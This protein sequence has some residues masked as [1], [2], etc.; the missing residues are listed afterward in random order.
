MQAQL[1][2]F[3]TITETIE[4]V[5]SK[6]A[7][8]AE[9]AEKTDITA[10]GFVS[11]AQKFIAENNKYFFYLKNRNLDEIEEIDNQLCKKMQK[12]GNTDEWFLAYWT[13]QTIA[14]EKIYRE[15]DERFLARYSG[16]FW[17]VISGD[18]VQE[19]RFDYK[20]CLG[21]ENPNRRTVPN[22]HIEFHTVKNSPLTHTGYLS[23]FLTCI[24]FNEVSSMEELIEL[25]LVE[26]LKVRE[27]ILFSFDTEPNH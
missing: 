22:P 8:K 25:I 13:A 18:E 16:K 19:V 15:L 7:V 20:P 4:Q 12:A 14:L 21:F 6:T 9:C 5:K 23:H 1:S 17:L 26:K 27:E 24:P 3:D 11:P 2:L 10:I